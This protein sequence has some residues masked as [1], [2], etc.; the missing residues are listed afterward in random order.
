[1]H[2]LNKIIH[3]SDNNFFKTIAMGPKTFES[4]RG[5]EGF[6]KNYNKGILE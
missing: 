2:N 3:I 1:M 4:S 6:V 5:S